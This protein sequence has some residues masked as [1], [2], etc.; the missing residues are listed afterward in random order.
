LTFERAQRFALIVY[1]GGIDVI[2]FLKAIKIFSIMLIASM[3]AVGIGVAS[4]N[5]VIA[6]KSAQTSEMFE[7]PGI[8]LL[9]VT[10]LEGSGSAITD[11]S[12]AVLAWLD[13][14][15]DMVVAAFAGVI[16]V[17]WT[18]ALGFSIYGLLMLFGLAVGFVGLAIGFLRGLIQK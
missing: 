17:F 3:F 4:A 18:P 1:F 2:K 6:E 16:A 15:V 8:Q 14:V 9:E 10:T 7:R 5:A 11:F 12:T 13:L